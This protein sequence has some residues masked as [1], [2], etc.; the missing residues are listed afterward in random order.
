MYSRLGWTGQSN[1]DT[2]SSYLVYCLQAGIFQAILKLAAQLS[3]YYAA[4]GHGM[5]VCAFP[6]GML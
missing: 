3:L 2:P 6:T 4:P 1:L 5:G